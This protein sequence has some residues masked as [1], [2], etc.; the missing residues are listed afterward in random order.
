MKSNLL[1]KLVEESF[2]TYHDEPALV[3]ERGSMSYGALMSRARQIG[4]WMDGGVGVVGLAGGREAGMYAGILAS[5]MV[6]RPY[7]PLNEKFPPGRLRHM[8]KKSGCQLVLGAPEYEGLV[9]DLVSESGGRMERLPGVVEVFPGAEV[10]AWRLRMGG[11]SDCGVPDLNKMAYVLFTSG[12]TGQ[13]KGIGVSQ[14]NLTAYLEHAVARFG[15]KPGD[16]ASQMFELTFDLSVH[17]LFVTWL[18]GGAL[19][20]P[21]GADM[22]A[23]GRY[24]LREGITHWF[25]VPAMA[26]LLARLRMLRPSVFPGLRQSLFC[27]E[28]LPQEVAAAWRRAS[29]ASTIWNLYG[30]TEATIAI[31]AHEFTGETEDAAHGGLVPIGIVFPSQDCCVVDKSLSPL[32]CGQKGELLLGGTQVAKGYIGDEER[33]AAAFV[34]APAGRMGRW[35]RTGDLAVQDA[36]GVLRYLGR[37]D[38]QIQVL[39][40]RVELGEVES[41]LRHVAATTSVAAIGWPKNGLV[42]EGVVAFL[43]GR[44]STDELATLKNGCSGLLPSY[45]VP[46]R[47]IPVDEMPLN[48]N[49]KTDRAAL[50][51]LLSS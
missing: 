51:S 38:S 40:H 32:A 34:P 6:G 15:V 41:V 42:Y 13:P 4:R 25:S 49:G 45:M 22:A 43:E 29:P 28:A 44:R 50:A 9:A 12:S 16:R 20:V 21:T 48:S 27:G 24:M 10:A 37:L 26:A 5:V 7:M 30:P 11:E 3:M 17:D 8:V 2:T 46:S 18:G 1:L 36:D 33:T 47:I 35:Y 31:T 14:E 19:H 23:P 39:G